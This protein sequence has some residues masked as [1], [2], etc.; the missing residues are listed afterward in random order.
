MASDG[1]DVYDLALALAHHLG[2]SFQII[3]ERTLRASLPQAQ[4][5]PARLFQ[6]LR[7]IKELFSR[8]LWRSWFAFTLFGFLLY[9]LV[10]EARHV[11]ISEI[12]VDSSRVIFILP[13]LVSGLGLPLAVFDVNVLGFQKQLISDGR[14]VFVL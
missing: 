14:Q 4:L 6:G 11:H 5:V 8:F 12:R 1:R 3:L 7:L 13:R 9:V 2:L 10:R